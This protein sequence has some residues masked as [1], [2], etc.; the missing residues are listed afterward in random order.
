[1]KIIESAL[2]SDLRVRAVCANDVFSCH[3]QFAELSTTI[4]P[5]HTWIFNACLKRSQESDGAMSLA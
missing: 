1:M 3:G 5:S 2:F 4:P